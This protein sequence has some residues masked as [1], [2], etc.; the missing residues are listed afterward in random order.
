QHGGHRQFQQHRHP[1]D[2]E[3]QTALHAGPGHGGDRRRH[4]ALRHG[5]QQRL[6]YLRS[7]RRGGLHRLQEQPR[8]RRGQRRREA[9]GPRDAGGTY[10]DST[11]L[12]IQGTNPLGSAGSP[13]T[14][15]GGALTTGTPNFTLVNPVNF[16]NARVALN[17]VNLTLSG[18]V[19]LTGANALTLS[20][21]TTLT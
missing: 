10:L 8:R 12:S 18:L 6:R 21:Q 11:N 1:G 7:Q 16:T 14:L 4:P 15:V 13:V 9:D 2:G 20:Q 5:R 3:R 19:T 17:A